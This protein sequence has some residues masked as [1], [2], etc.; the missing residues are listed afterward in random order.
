MEPLI[1]RDYRLTRSDDDCLTL[2]CS[3]CSLA[4]SW[5]R[6]S[7]CCCCCCCCCSSPADRRREDTGAPDSSVPGSPQPS[8]L[9]PQPYRTPETGNSAGADGLSLNPCTSHGF[10]SAREVGASRHNGSICPRRLPQY[11]DLS[12]SRFFCLLLSGL[13]ERLDTRQRSLSSACVLSSS[14]HVKRRRRALHMLSVN[15]MNHTQP[16]TFHLLILPTPLTCC[17]PT[18]TPASL[19]ASVSCTITL[20]LFA[21][22]SLRSSV[23][24]MAAPTCVMNL[25][26]AS[27][28]GSSYNHNMI[29]KTSLNGE[30]DQTASRSCQQ[31]S[32]FCSRPL[33]CTS[34]GSRPS[35]AQ[36]QG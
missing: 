31:R 36:R 30:L 15:T 29:I 7:C 24:A 22:P 3:D 4:F 12:V 11:V 16:C 2:P 6:W 23:G 10:I 13:A 8:A 26:V 20:P 28:L 17:V 5:R 1:R 34:S 35:A 9:S 33:G 27:I 18:F 21:P 19:Q 14:T 25:P 32:R